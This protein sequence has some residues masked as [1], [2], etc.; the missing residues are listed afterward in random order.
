MYEKSQSTRKDTFMPVKSPEIAN[1]MTGER[2]E[3]VGV[4]AIEYPATF[5]VVSVSRATEPRDALPAPTASVRVL[6]ANMNLV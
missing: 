5:P 3:S 2:L 6:L 4:T 1:E